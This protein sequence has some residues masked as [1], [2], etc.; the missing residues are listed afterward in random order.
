VLSASLCLSLAER[1]AAQLYKYAIST[2]VGQYPSG[3]QG[4]AT[5][6]LLAQPYG[7]ALD[8]QGN[9]YVPDY[10]NNRVRKIVALGQITTIAGTGVAGF[11][12]DA[13]AAISAQLNGPSAV[14]WIQQATFIFT[15][16]ATM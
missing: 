8:S 12:G 13:S 15:T 14:A 7:V 9:L 2:A 10:L 5:R 6:A 1:S 3:D 16:A 11:S 4:P